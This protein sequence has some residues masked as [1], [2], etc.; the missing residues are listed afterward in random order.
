MLKFKLCLLWLF[1]DVSVFVEV[2]A[3][4]L[5]LGSVK[6]PVCLMNIVGLNVFREECVV[7][8]RVLGTGDDQVWPGHGCLVAQGGV[9]QV[10]RGRGGGAVCCADAD[11]RRCCM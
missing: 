8:D 10:F 11:R 6:I 1:L 4:Q 5:K 3:E 2:V 9:V 7:G